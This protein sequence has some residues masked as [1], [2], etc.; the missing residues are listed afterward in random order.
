MHRIESE[1][2]RMTSLVDDLLLL[3][4][5]DRRRPLERDRVDV[6]RLALDVVEGERV[7]HPDREYRTQL[8]RLLVLGD[9]ARLRQVLL[10]LLGER[11]EPHPGR[12]ADR[13]LDPT[14]RRA[15]P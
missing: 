15:T 4:R 7:V 13:A 9:E 1:A 11:G 8:D 10:N 12:H 14:A 3:A 6:A 5:L 2:T